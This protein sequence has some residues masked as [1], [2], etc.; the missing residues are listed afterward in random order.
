MTADAVSL[1]DAMRQRRSV[2]G[3]QDR[4]VPEDVLEQVFSLA[5]LAP[6]NCNIQPWKVFVASGEARDELRRRM[7]EKVAAGIPIEPDFEP[8]AGTFNG[9]YRQRQIDC[10]VEL[11]NNMGIARDDKPARQRA[12]LRNFELFDAP[13]VV[14]IGMERSF[15]T[16]VAMDVGM[17]IQSLMLAMTAHGIGCC[18]Q[19]SMRYYPNDVRDVFGEPDS[20]V[21]MVG[22]SFGYEDETVAAN[23]TRV[24]RIP[25]ADSVTFKQRL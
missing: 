23:R 1:A 15:G 9:V 16:T 8:N 20:T 4:Q 17:Y 11:Y 6:S 14:F 21:I 18:A 19:G 22:I 7:V 12:Q 13:H 2:R 5:Q 24:G 3:F 25:L 10:A